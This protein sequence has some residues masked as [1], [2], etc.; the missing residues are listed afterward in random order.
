M[1]TASS[2][3]WTRVT[4]SISYNDDYE[5]TSVVLGALYKR[6]TKYSLAQLLY[7]RKTANENLTSGETSRGNRFSSRLDK[8]LIPIRE[9]VTTSNDP[10]PPDNSTCFFYS[11]TIRT[12][13]WIQSPCK[14][15]KSDLTWNDGLNTI[16]NHLY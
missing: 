16:A 7:T 10:L 3:I 4:G 11:S 8:L 12:I 14:R 1:Q 13:P 2:R 6:K 15:P 9:Q 5:T